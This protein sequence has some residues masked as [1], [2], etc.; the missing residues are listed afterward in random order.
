METVT[1]LRYAYYTEAATLTD[2]A[3]GYAFKENKPLRR[4]AT[5]ML[6]AMSIGGA[7][8]RFSTHEVVVDE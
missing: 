4:Y 1:R 6:V 2:Y 7:T 8:A 5:R 3:T